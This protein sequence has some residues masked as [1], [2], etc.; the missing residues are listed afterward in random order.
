MIGA[1]WG[2]IAKQGV[3]NMSKLGYTEY[4]EGLRHGK[5]DYCTG[6]RSTHLLVHDMSEYGAGYRAGI[7]ES[8]T[9][10]RQWLRNEKKE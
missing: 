5:R 3:W 9:M 6:I 2:E 10:Q 1:A 4:E 8:E 7:V